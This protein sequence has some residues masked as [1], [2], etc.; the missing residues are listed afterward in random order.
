M[1]QPLMATPPAQ[2]EALYDA[3]LE[4]EKAGGRIRQLN[5]PKSTDDWDDSEASDSEAAWS[6]SFRTT[7]FP[8][9]NATF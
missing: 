5:T 9:P 6:T 1:K 4:N 7:A 3:A 8:A 2:A